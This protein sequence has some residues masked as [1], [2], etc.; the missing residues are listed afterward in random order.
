MTFK[1]VYR[2]R[3][4]VVFG[5]VGMLMVIGA[6]LASDARAEQRFVDPLFSDI[7]VRSG[8]QFGTGIREEAADQPLLL[9]V[10][11]PR[12]DLVQNRP[13]I[14][15]AFPGGFVDGARDDPEMVALATQFAR[16]GYV[17][18]SIDYRLIEERP[19]NNSELEISIVR[20]VHDLRAAVRFFREDAANLNEFGTDG[21][22]I[23]VGGVSAGAVMAAVAG[24]LDEG[25]ELRESVAD[26]LSENGG[27][28]GNSSTN[29]EFSSDVSGVLQ[30]SGAIRSL[31]WIEPGEPPIY[32][33]HEDFD[34]VVPC[35][36]L[37]GLSLIHI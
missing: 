19:R 1:V 37:P 31:S 25:D 35:D 24:V 5:V 21:E 22:T 6:G 11:A 29:T 10:Y 12:N 17:A 32:A 8:I 15:L 14:I 7:E 34:P 4:P 36:T 26:F 13:V 2:L 16:R 33:A 9:D 3:E 27:M 23:F 20:A 28:A 30:I 18:A